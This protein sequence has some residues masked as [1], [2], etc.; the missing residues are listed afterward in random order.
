MSNFLSVA[1]GKK[2]IVSLTGL[3]L[4]SF[5]CIHMGVNLLLIFDSS[6]R[7]FNIGANFM[8]TNPIIMVIEP[9]LGLGFLI[10]ICWTLYICIGNLRARPVRYAKSNASQSSSWASKNM[11]ILGLLILTFLAIHLYNFYYPIKFDHGSMPPEVTIDGVSMHNTYA[12]VAGLFMQSNVYCLLYMLGSI[13]L[14]L[15]LSHGFWSAFQTIGLNN[16]IWIPRIK[17]VSYLFAVLIGAGFAIIPLYFM[18]K[19]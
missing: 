10:H 19:F 13:L 15:H 7:L 9:I 2:L 5:I 8:G 4:I 11:V 6:G 1:I 12:L 16:K 18:I 3:F 14:G 17:F